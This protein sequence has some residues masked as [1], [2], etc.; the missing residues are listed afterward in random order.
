M[1]IAK[2][3]AIALRYSICTLMPVV[4]AHRPALAQCGGGGGMSCGGHSMSGRDM[5]HASHSGGLT[6]GHSTTGRAPGG[7]GWRHPGNQPLGVPGR[8]NWMMP[9]G[10]NSHGSATGA[11][12]ISSGWS[13]PPFGFRAS[14]QLFSGLA[15]PTN[16]GRASAAYR[17]SLPGH[18]L[19]HGNGTDASAGRVARG[20]DDRAP[21]ALLRLQRKTSSSSL[22]PLLP[23]ADSDGIRFDTHSAHQSHQ[24]LASDSSPGPGWTAKLRSR[25][26][27]DSSLPGSLGQRS[28]TRSDQTTLPTPSSVTRASQIAC[29]MIGLRIIVRDSAAR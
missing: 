13:S 10:H 23:S 11:G 16:H 17:T 12:G 2:T 29:F 18:A 26:Q 20:V 15:K 6:N 5:G 8:S 28:Q 9:S 24:S 19:S 1:F 4:L 22:L 14:P 27:S 3:S 21:V 25:V 7:T